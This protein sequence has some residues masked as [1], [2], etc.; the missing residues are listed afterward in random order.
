MAA[1]SLLSD[2]AYRVR[3]LADVVSVAAD[4]F[5]AG[6]DKSMRMLDVSTGKCLSTVTAAHQYEDVDP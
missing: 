1:E 3:S 2:A 4:L 6:K 5:A